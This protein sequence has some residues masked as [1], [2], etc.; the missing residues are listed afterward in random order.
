[1][2]PR[3]NIYLIKYFSICLF[4]I[5][6]FIPSIAFSQTLSIEKLIE[7]LKTDDVYQTQ[8]FDAVCADL[9]LNFNEKVFISQSKEVQGYLANHPN[10]R[11]EVRMFMYERTGYQKIPRPD[12]MNTALHYLEIIKMAG[13]IGD[14]Q[15][16]SDLYTRYAMVCK[17][18][19]KLYYLLKCIEIREHIGTKFFSDIAATYYHASE[20]LYNIS[21]FKSSASYA[22]RGVELY[23]NKGKRDFLFHY[24][25]AVDIA[26]AA[27]LQINKPDSAIYYYKHIGSLMDDRAVN[28]KNYKSPMTP[29]MIQ[30]WRG[31]VNG[32]IAKAYILQRKYD[33]AYPL[34]LQN[35]KTSIEF[36][37]LDDVAGIQNSLAQID[38]VRHNIRLA[39]SRYLQAYHLTTKS[40]RL[41]LL[42]DAAEGASSSFAALGQYDSAYV[43]HRRFVQAKNTLDKN[44]NQSRLDNVKEQVK[45]EKTQKELLQSQNNLV[46]QKR[47]RN[48]ILIAIIF[49]TIIA[50]L[51]YNRK[52]LQLSLQN[53]KLEKEK[54]KSENEIAHAQQQIDFFTHYIAEKN[55]LIKQ[56]ETQ[57]T[58]TDNSAINVALQNF[59]ILTED[60]W[61]MFKTNFETI[62]PNFLYRLKQKMPQITQGE[63]RIILLAKLGFNNKEMANATGVSSETIRS[64]IS[65]MRKKFDLNTDI[66]AIANEI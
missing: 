48:S 41:S 31:V 57:L 24:I 12:R 20:L 55:S 51:L 63:Q 5:L 16:L 36:S 49:L 39:L 4:G 21:N 13:F 64:V 43:Y 52:R 59:T 33:E 29:Q 11:L 54:Q 30:I 23:T 45:F 53:E 44:I 66:R 60:D 61:Q 8:K 25:L 62:N 34:L 65:R 28:P 1:M 46:N 18:S 3:S 22:A 32:G 40:Y 10:K 58:A 50:L 35:L 17:E 47:I 14:E 27:Y 56:L 37:Q 2:M 38:I 26:A 19:E 15:L 6:F 42:V 9:V 7:E